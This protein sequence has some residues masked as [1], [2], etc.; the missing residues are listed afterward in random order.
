MPLHAAVTQY[1]I[2]R[3]KCSVCSNN[4]MYRIRI[5]KNL[6]P[7]YEKRKFMDVKWCSNAA[8]HKILPNEGAV[9]TFSDG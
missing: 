6:I 5:F 8:N 7:Q 2:Y 9:I 3:V 1:F 4:I